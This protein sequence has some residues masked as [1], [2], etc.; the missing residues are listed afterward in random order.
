MWNLED[1]VLKT[2]F[3]ASWLPEVWVPIASLQIAPSSYTNIRPTQRGQFQTFEIPLDGKY[4]LV[5]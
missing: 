5:N 3:V 1:V 2:S 4:P